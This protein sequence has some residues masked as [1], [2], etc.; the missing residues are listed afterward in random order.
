MV[1]F[2]EGKL[3]RTKRLLKGIDQPCAFMACEFHSEEVQYNCVFLQRWDKFVL[4]SCP[5][6]VF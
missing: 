1:R 4:N 3:E 5:N 2:A 6:Y